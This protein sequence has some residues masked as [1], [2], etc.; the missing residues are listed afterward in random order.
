VKLVLIEPRFSPGQVVT[1]VAM[2]LESPAIL[3]VEDDDNVRD[4]ISSLLTDAG[5]RVENAATSW[6]AIALTEER[7]RL[8]PI[9]ACRAV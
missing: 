6:E 9:S 8:S 1:V 7:P 2:S 4:T 3:V 5:F